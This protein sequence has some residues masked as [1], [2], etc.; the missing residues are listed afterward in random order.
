MR[1]EVV[2]KSILTWLLHTFKLLR[3][4]HDA[5]ACGTLTR[6]RKKL[7]SFMSSCNEMSGPCT[8]PREYETQPYNSQSLS[9][10]PFTATRPDACAWTGG[11]RRL[12]VR[13]PESLRT[14]QTISRRVSPERNSG[15]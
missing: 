13:G 4:T 6:M 3:C 15:I 14:T 9:D 10:A 2:G 5:I 8:I 12:L 1:D 11:T 7:E